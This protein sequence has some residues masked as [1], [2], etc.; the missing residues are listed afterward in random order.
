MGPLLQLAGTR[1][2]IGI[3]DTDSI[4]GMCTTYLGFRLA[5]LLQ[6]E[7]AEFE[8]YP[9][10]V[11]LNPNVPWKTRGNGAVGM[12]VNVS[13]P[14]AARKIAIDAVSLYSDLENGANPAAVFC[15]GGIPQPVRDLSREALHVMVEQERARGI[16]ERHCSGLFY[17]GSGQ[18]M[19]GAAAAIGYEFGDSTLELLSY[20]REENR[21]TPR[22]IWP[23]D[24]R[25]IQG[26]YPDTFNS[27]DE[28]RGTSIIAPR[29]PDPVFY[30]IRG[31][32]ASSLLGASE[33]VRTPERLEGYMIYRSNQGTAD[34]L[35]YVIDAADPRPYSSGTISGVIST[36]PVVR[37]GGH[38]F[39]EINA[40]G[41]MVPCA[42]YKE[43]GMTDAAAL[44]RG[45]DKVVVGGGIRRESGSHPKVLNVEFARVERLARIYRMANPYCTKCSKS[46]KSKGIGQGFKCTRCGAASIHRVERE[47]P[48]G[49]SVGLYLPVASS[50]RHLARPYGRQG[51]TSR[52]QFDGASPWL[53]VFDSGE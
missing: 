17:T 10:L 18:G 21:G 52:I 29:G 48:R 44:L 51:R 30:G 23:E 31:E 50:Q 43:S 47:I 7:G 11:R 20:R 15:E 12:T 5:R 33:M 40:G 42:V 8:D 34:H 37:E 38:V 9:R 22:P 24:V 27:Y 53:G 45:G 6:K 14:E 16:I 2:H 4:K 3:D 36:E 26:A 28:A 32:L 19:V 39:F 13:D 41:S 1:L 25:G 49:I 46:M 35:E